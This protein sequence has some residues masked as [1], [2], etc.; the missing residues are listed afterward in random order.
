[1]KY[2]LV[3][4]M[5]FVTVFMTACYEDFLE[6]E[7]IVEELTKDVFSSEAEIAQ[8]LPAAYH[9]MRWEFNNTLGDGYCMPLMYTDIRSDDVII[10]NALYQPPSHDLQNF[11][12]LNSS[13]LFVKSIWLKFFTGVAN[14]NQ[15]IQGLVVTEVLDANVKALYLAEAKFLRAYYYF[16]LVKNFGE[17]PLFGDEPADISNPDEVKRKPIAEVYAQIE[18]DLII[19]AEGLPTVQNEQYRATRGAALGLLAKVYLYQEKWQAAADAAQDVIDLGIYELEENYVDNFKIDNEFGKESIF[20]LDFINDPAG[21]AWTTGKQTSL[22]LQFFAPAFAPTTIAGWNYN[23]TTSDLLKAFNDEG[24]TER[25]D[26]TIM[27]E[28]HTFDSQILTDAGF[29]PIP[30]GWFSGGINGPESGGRYGN[31]Y[32]YSLKYFL[33]PEELEASSP[34][35]QQ[36]AL[37]QKVMRYAEVLLILAEA[38]VNGASGS[39]QEAFN[40]VRERA[41]LSSKPLTLE[42]L[43][44]ERRLELATEWNRFHD[45]VRWGDAESRLENFRRGRDEYLPIPV[46][47]ILAT[48]QDENGEFILTQNPGY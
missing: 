39:G 25:R 2:K 14:S 5:C 46:D 20:E 47:D 7:P 42:A 6:E 13:N 1:M 3:V 21:G 35:L 40:Q 8:L 19:A 33:T 37:N 27:Q 48:G 43:K 17:V 15:I 10:E 36:S 22:S 23:L 31:D 41:G 34:G 4:L 16:E 26:A 30:D 18:S 29:N 45:L 24:D 11:T 32:A 12:T 44:L 38:T 9:P 28:G